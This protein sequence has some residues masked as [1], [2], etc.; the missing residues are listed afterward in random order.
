VKIRICVPVA[1][2]NPSELP[3][4][5][6]RAESEGA[7]LIEVRLD[8]LESIQGLEKVIAC[9]SVPLIATNRQYEQGGYR[10]QDEETRVRDLM[11]AAQKGFQ[12]VDIELT[13]RKL[14]EANSSLR[15]MGVKPIISFHETACTPTLSEM[16]KILEAQLG[17]GAEVCKLVTTA[18]SIEDN[19]SCFLL[20]SE[21]SRMARIVCFAMG[22]KGLLSRALSPLFG[23]YFTYAS[24]RKGLET[25]LGQITVSEL[26]QLYR[27]LG[28]GV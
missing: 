17:A 21:M 13:T 28:V 20:L 9:A 15:D 27:T 18:N 24:L 2:G 7:D 23:G 14:A 4:M 12:Y 19:V 5:V 11:K 10:A 8:Y 22:S 16:K 6:K 25:A 1:A 3:S 26:K